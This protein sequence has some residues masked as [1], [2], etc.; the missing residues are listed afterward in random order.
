MTDLH[1]TTAADELR[2]AKIEELQRRQAHAGRG[3]G[4]Q[5]VAT[6]SKIAAAGFG[7]ASML[8]LVGVMGLVQRNSGSNDTL[9]V[10]PPAQV[11]VV[12]HPAT[13]PD[14]TPA[15]LAATPNQPTVLNAQPTVRQAPASQAPAAKTSGSR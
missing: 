4:R 8:G 1:T 3:S 9:Q 14:A 7:M 11:V 2:R 13:T 15:V 6:G 12:I 5:G 10:A